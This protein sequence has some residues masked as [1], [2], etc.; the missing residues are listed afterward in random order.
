MVG[1]VVGD[2]G[3]VLSRSGSCC[4]ADGAAN[5]QDAAVLC[6]REAREDVEGVGKGTCMQARADWAASR[7]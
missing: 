2:A 7:C 1:D 5:D 6:A 3:P 4:T